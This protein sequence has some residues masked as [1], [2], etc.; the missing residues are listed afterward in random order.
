[1]CQLGA[2]DMARQGASFEQILAHY[3]PNTRLSAM[4][5]Q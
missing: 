5:A 1:M 4:A 2:A 3:Y